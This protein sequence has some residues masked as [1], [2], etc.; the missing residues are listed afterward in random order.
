MNI[1]EAARRSGLTA[2]TIRFYEQIGLIRPAPRAGNAYRDY[3]ERD[4]HV[5]RFVARAR[6]L[7]FSVEQ[8]RELL[9]L[10]A[11]RARASADVKAIAQAH[12]ADIERRVAEL[13][14]M[15]AT[16][17]HLVERCHGD[18]RPDCPI[19][20][21]LAASTRLARPASPH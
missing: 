15:R 18:D 11:D 2:K 20:E 21:E 7:G 4:V 9:A 6:A 5:L 17:R 14:A 19:L 10:Y 16:L 8:C 13:A 12:I 1:G 3:G